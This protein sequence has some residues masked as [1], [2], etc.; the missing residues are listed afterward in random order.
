LKN[1]DS[2]KAATGFTKQQ[3]QEL[4]TDYENAVGQNNKAILSIQDEVLLFLVY[5][6][7]YQTD[8][9]LAPCFGISASTV[10]RAVSKVRTQFVLLY[11]NLIKFPTGEELAKHAINFFGLEIIG[12][13]DNSEQQSVGPN[14]KSLQEIMYSGKQGQYTFTKLACISPRGICLHLSQSYNG[15]KNDLNTY[16][17]PSNCIQQKIDEK[18]FVMF[19]RGY[20]GVQHMGNGLLAIRAAKHKWEQAFNRAFNSI[21]IVVENFFARV[22]NWNICSQKYRYVTYDALLVN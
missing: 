8:D 18:Q 6:R 16:H 15:A 12:I 9:Q 3:Y 7:Q 5:I 19:D 17:M 1:N 22:K 2:F 11:G 13:V 14:E 10:E 21:R 4:V 20:N